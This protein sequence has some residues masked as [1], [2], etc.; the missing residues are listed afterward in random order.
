MPTRSKDAGA[1]KQALDAGTGTE[2]VPFEMPK[3]EPLMSC[4]WGCSFFAVFFIVVLA[5][6]LR[7]SHRKRGS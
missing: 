2:T 1:A 3:Q 6:M 4:G 5:W 7:D